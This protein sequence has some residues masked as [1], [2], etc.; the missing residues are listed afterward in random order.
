MKT[1][2]AILFLAIPG[3]VNA[4]GGTQWHLDHAPVDARDQ[5]SLQRGAKYFVNYC[6]GCHT[7]QYQRYERMAQDI[8]LTNDQVLE[9][10]IFSDQK[11]GET[12]TN[13]MPSDQAKQWFGATPPDLSLITRSRGNDW[14]YTYLRTFYRDESRPWGVNNAVF[15][16]VGMPHVLQELQGVLEPEY[17]EH[18][19]VKTLVAL[20]PGEPGQMTAEE[21]DQ[22]MGDLVNF[23][24]YVADPIKLK[25]ERMGLWVLVFLSVFFIFAYLLKKEYWRDVH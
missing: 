9:H 25:R 21:F 22:A 14:V 20:K 6:L 4:A 15:P 3:F 11:V 2:L 23:L 13:T 1:W 12:M 18:D 7:A 16:S 19:G 24:A 10:L 5:A 17:E 8:G